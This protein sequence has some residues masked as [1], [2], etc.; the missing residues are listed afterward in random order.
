MLLLLTITLTN[1]TVLLQRAG[2]PRYRADSHAFGLGTMELGL[3]NSTIGKGSKWWGMTGTNSNSKAR[4]WWVSVLFLWVSSLNWISTRKTYSQGYNLIKYIK[5]ILV[6]QYMK[7]STNKNP[8]L[9]WLN[10]LVKYYAYNTLGNILY[11][12]H[13]R[14]IRCTTHWK[15][16]I[17]TTHW[18]N[19]LY[20]TLEKYWLKLCKMVPAFQYNIKDVMGN[21]YKKGSWYLIWD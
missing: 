1:C 21:S 9:A 6:S 13:W 16:I 12:T 4:N 11:T 3:W 14:N 17:Y 15:N 8:G 2:L 10:T 20:T 5:Y 18:K 19:I 7:L